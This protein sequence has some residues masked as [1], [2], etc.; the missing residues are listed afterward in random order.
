[1]TETQPPANSTRAILHGLALQQRELSR[2][3]S[4]LARLRKEA[5]TEIT[6][7][8]A[9]LDAS[10]PYV[11]SELEEECEDEG[12]QCEDEGAEHDGR[13]PDVDNEP[14]LGSCD[15]SIWGGDQTRWSS[16]GRGDLESDPAE[17]GIGDLEGLLE[18]VGTQD[19]QEGAMA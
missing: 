2:A 1:M 9:F 8:I 11:M 13:E 10:D 7:L 4:D 12:A 3:L 16:G 14:S 15:P 6:R 17:S 19:W 18:Q 5:S